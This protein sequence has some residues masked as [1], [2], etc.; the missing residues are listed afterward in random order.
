MCVDRIC[1]LE[2]LSSQVTWQKL[3]H[4]LRRDGVGGGGMQSIPSGCKEKR[5]GGADA[6]RCSI[7]VV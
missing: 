2:E 1:T 3:F 6:I 5:R 4:Q 7:I